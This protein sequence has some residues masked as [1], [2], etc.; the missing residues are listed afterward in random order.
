MDGQGAVTDRFPLHSRHPR[1]AI[2]WLLLLGVVACNRGELSRSHAAQ[3]LTARFTNSPAIRRV[4]RATCVDKYHARFPF[5]FYR[6]GRP[7]T[8]YRALEQAGLVTVAE[9]PATSDQCGTP[10]PESLRIMTVT[11]TPQGQAAQWPEHQE[12]LGGWDVVVGRRELVEV[13]AIRPQPDPTRA[14]CRI[15][16]A[17]DPDDGWSRPWPDLRTTRGQCHVSA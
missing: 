15:S 4:Y 3:E 5:F 11:L 13:T 8:E 14:P 6:H 1:Y 9:L 12:G 10:Y 16:V 2:V 7:I 17:S